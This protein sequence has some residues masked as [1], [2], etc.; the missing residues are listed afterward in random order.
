VGGSL[1]AKEEKRTVY[2][3]YMGKMPKPEYD[4]W[5]VIS[6]IYELCEMVQKRECQQVGISVS[7]LEIL[8]LVKSQPKPLTAYKLANLLSHQHHSVVEIVNRLRRKGLIERVVIDGKSSLEISEAGDEVL[9]RVLS[10]P[11]LGDVLASLGNDKLRRM[12]DDLM[13]LRQAAMREL[14]F[15]DRGEIQVKSIEE[16]RVPK[17]GKEVRASK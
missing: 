1:G 2:S 4:A 5:L 14:G 10:R 17:S 3:M 15:L 7:A 11:I 6:Q 12:M 9:I 13:P 16:M 8:Y